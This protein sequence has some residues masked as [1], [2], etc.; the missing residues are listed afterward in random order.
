MRLARAFA[1]AKAQSRGAL[2]TYLMGG[3]PSLAESVE[4]AMACIRGGADIV[5]LGF[6]FSDPIADG[7]TIQRAAERALAAKVT[8]ES[9]LRI[10]AEMRSQAPETPLV[11]MGYLNP[12]LAMGPARFFTRAAEAGVDAVILP[13]LPPE[14]AAELRAEATRTGLSLISML[15]PTST[16]ARRAAVLS[17]ASG[18]T[19]FVSVTGVTG[20]RVGQAD[21]SAPLAAIRAESSVPVVVGFGIGTPDQARA[22][23]K[24]ADGVVVGSAIVERIARR[25]PLEPFVVSLRAALSL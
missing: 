17:V 24:H 3:D 13:D 23:C 11:L 25:E 18:F 9:V 6:P 14:E 20:T 15:A 2:V 7:P 21:I 4:S 10:A 12:V 5:E 8:L 16:P 1:R 19:Y 22:A